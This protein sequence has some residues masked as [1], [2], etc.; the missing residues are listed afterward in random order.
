MRGGPMPHNRRKAIAI[1]KNIIELGSKKDWKG[2]LKLVERD[3]ADCNNINY[4]TVMVHFGRMPSLD[5][6]DPRFLAFLDTMWGKIEKRGF[7]WTQGRQAANIVHAIGKMKLRNPSAGNILNWLSS[8][9]VAK[10]FVEEAQNSA[11]GVQSAANA[12]WAFATLGHAAPILLAEIEARS[13]WLVQNGNPQEIAN[14][15]W[16][17]ATL[18]TEAPKLLAAIESESDWL[19]QNSKPQQVVNTVWAFAKLHTKAPKLMA[20]LEAR[21]EWIFENK[22]TQDVANT[23][24]AFASLNT[25]APNLLAAIEAR[26]NWLVENGST[27][28]VASTAWSFATLKTEAPALLCAIDARSD[29]LAKN[30]STQEIANTVWAFA[31][32]KTAAPKLFTAIDTRSNWLV[33]NGSTQEV[34]TTAWAFATVKT[35]APKL[36]AAIEARSDSHVTNGNTQDAANTAWAFATLQTKAPK[37]LA[38]IEARADWFVEHGTT[39]EVANA[40]WAFATLNTEAPQLLAAVEARSDWLVKNGSTQNVANTLWAFASLRT[41][42]PILFTAIEARSDWLVKHGNAQTVANIAWSFATLGF[43]ATTFFNEL[44]NNEMTTLCKE[45]NAQSLSILC[46]AI[47]L[48]GRVKESEHLLLKLWDKAI[49][50]FQTNVKFSDEALYQLAQTQTFATAWRVTL[51]TC[52]AS[53]KKRITEALTARGE[54]GNRISRSS[55]EVSVILKN[56]GFEHEC[57]VAPDSSLL[58]GMMAIDFACKKLK[59]AIEYDGESHFLKALSSGE[60][61]SK[62]DGRTKAKHRLLKQLGWTAINLDFRDRVEARRKSNEKQWLRTELN[63]AGVVLE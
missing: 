26:S 20:A 27:Q 59:V 11:G 25:D 5:T 29:W 44:D 30:G 43:E 17:F 22:N 39:Q 12:A 28:H 38:A 1:N 55:K 46:F 51:T 3:E 52:P 32:L 33:Q 36:L 41:E 54:E 56:I 19:F 2:I 37:L 50:L 31:A 53:M 10:L 6:A 23:A 40:V 4:A 18:K 13:D 14:T 57:E 45:Q 48:V 15:V 62:W 60:L 24:W 9:Q 58:G 34:A 47:T 49:Q 42:A 8:E 61:T 7:S 35:E 16:A 21:P 63:K